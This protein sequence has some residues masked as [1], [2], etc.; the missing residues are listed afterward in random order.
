MILMDGLGN[1]TVH[2]YTVNKENHEASLFT[3]FLSINSLRKIP[4]ADEDFMGEIYDK[5]SEL[6]GLTSKARE[7]FDK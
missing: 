2:N 7:N 5:A 4:D 1:V 6:P 3:L